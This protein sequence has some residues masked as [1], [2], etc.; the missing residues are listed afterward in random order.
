MTVGLPLDSVLNWAETL[1]G[2][3]AEVYAR[4]LVY[5]LGTSLTS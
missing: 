4:E 5:L 3:G 2:F 1:I